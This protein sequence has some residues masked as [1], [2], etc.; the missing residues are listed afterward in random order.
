MQLTYRGTS[1]NVVSST[2]EPI[3]T[4]IV[5]LYR[6]MHHKIAASVQETTPSTQKLS[7]RGIQY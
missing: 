4:D 1:Y 5:G 3:E 6:G 7:Y 2:I